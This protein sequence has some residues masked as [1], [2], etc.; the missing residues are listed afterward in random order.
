[1]D[2]LRLGS[3]KPAPGSNR[4]KVRKGRGASSGKGRSC[5]RGRGGSGHRAGLSRKASFEGGQMPLARRLPKRGFCNKRFALEYEIINIRQIQDKFK[6]DEVVNPEKLKEK[7]LVR[8]KYKV[9]ILGDG[10]IKKKI[11]VSGCTLSTAAK[12]KIE[13]AGGEVESKNS[14]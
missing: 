3:L 11:K 1:M 12:E 6:S 5:G 13:K 9:K 4:G 10:E 8:G 2:I 7:G 14:V